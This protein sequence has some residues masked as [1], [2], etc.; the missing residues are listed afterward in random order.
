MQVRTQAAGGRPHPAASRKASQVKR[1]FLHSR[2]ASG[3]A[4]AQEG[5]AQAMPTG[6]C[7]TRQRPQAR[8]KKSG[9][10]LEEIITYGNPEVTPLFFRVI[11]QE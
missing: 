11:F 6:A 4:S 7:K 3:L 5:I 10:L 2:L 1:I 8:G 9:C